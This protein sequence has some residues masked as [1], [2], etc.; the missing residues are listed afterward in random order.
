[1]P[2]ARKGAARRRAKRRILKAVKGYR[3]G[4]SRLIRTAKE[5][6]LRA[7]AFAYRDR[8]TRKRDFR[9]LWITRI[10]AAANERDLSYSKLMDG[11]RKANVAL[12]RKMLAELA[13]NDPE[14][15]DAVVQVA[16]EAR[17]A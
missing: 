13:V 5:A 1:M 14:G 3:G 4:R 6:I 17:S 8:R 9:S 16:K 10:R 7:G 12:D 15:F 11:L 2:R